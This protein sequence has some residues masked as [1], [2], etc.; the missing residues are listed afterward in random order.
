[1][2]IIRSWQH[3]HRLQTIDYIIPAVTLMSFFSR[4]HRLHTCCKALCGKRDPSLTCSV[5]CYNVTK[6]K[7]KTK[8][9]CVPAE[10]HPEP[11]VQA[12]RRTCIPSRDALHSGHH[13]NHPWY[14]DCPWINAWWNDQ[15][16]DAACV[17]RTTVTVS[18]G[19]TLQAH[20]GWGVDLRCCFE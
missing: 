17:Q 10:E 11:L 3:H 19:G 1:M 12:R 6:T 13:R 7:S 14:P 18:V 5:T 2:L 15:R 4:S 20:T 9:E 16:I 8:G